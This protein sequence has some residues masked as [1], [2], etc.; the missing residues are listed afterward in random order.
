MLHGPHVQTCNNCIKISLVLLIRILSAILQLPQLV[1]L[2]M[3]SHSKL[4]YTTSVWKKLPKNEMELFLFTTIC[5]C[6]NDPENLVSCFFLH[7]CILKLSFLIIIIEWATILLFSIILCICLTPSVAQKWNSAVQAELLF[8]P[9][10]YVYELF[11]QCAKYLFIE[12][13]CETSIEIQV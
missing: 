8:K 12:N 13:I 11:M 1:L 5:L 3:L 4:P 9:L 6:K 10:N 2:K 7:I